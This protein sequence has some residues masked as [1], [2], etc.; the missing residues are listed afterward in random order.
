[1]STLRQSV[2]EYL[3][4]RRALGFRL[5]KDEH[6][7]LDF[8]DF[9]KRRHAP[10]ITAKLAVEWASRPASTSANYHAGRL[11]AVRSFARYRILSDTRTE[12]PAADLLPR[13]RSAF[14]PH[15]FTQDDIRRILAESLWR[16]GGAKWIVYQGRYTIFGLLAVT[17]MRVSEALNLDVDDVDLGEGVLT[18][19]NTKFGKSRLVPLHPTTTVALKCYKEER[20]TFLARKLAKPFFISQ[21]GQRISIHLLDKS[22][23]R[24]T[25]RLGMRDPSDRTG[26][27]LHDLRHTMAVEVLRRCYNASGN[28]E[29]RLPALSTYLGHSHLNFTY[30]Y[31][32]QNPGLMTEAMERLQ[33]RW[34]T[35]A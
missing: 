22:F 15:I 35:P 31:L 29:R 16:R 9:M 3:E 27:R 24:V 17:G 28:P 1:M 18:I 26:P 33:H 21:I 30:W 8:A 34:E 7:L 11:R 19:R 25:Q 20:D 23:R 12:V 6:L 14:Q 5:K 13:Q 32:H 2:V 4:L 10:H